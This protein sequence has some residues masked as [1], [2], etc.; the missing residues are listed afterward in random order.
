MTMESK[1][2]L[3][4]RPDVDRNSPST[5]GD[6]Q[7]TMEEIAHLQR[8]A[9]VGEL[10]AE[11][12]HEVNQP[13]TAI[14]WFSEA[15]LSRLREAREKGEAPSEQ[16]VETLETI[17]QQAETAQQLTAR[18]FGMARMSADREQ[19]FTLEEVW[20]NVRP[21]VDVLAQRHHV[22]LMISGL[23]DLPPLKGDRLRIGQVL[24][25]LVRNAI[26]A[27]AL[28]PEDR[29]R[30]AIR[31]AHCGGWVEVAVRDYG[32]GAPPQVLERVFHR[33]FTTKLAGTGL[34]LAISKSIIDEHGGE[35]EVE[36]N[37][38]YGLT[39]RFRLPCGQVSPPGR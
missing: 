20:G 23:D 24:L 13:L 19:R 12:A 6:R 10:C 5:R 15:A 34:G 38:D 17:A 9:V 14:R 3:F 36:P 27:V 16:L 31:G 29:R 33:F 28:G 8:L 26:E 22:K 2:R 37:P 11:T 39:F 21:L 18:L 32:E 4:V 7:W 1:D 30:V 25:N 35:I